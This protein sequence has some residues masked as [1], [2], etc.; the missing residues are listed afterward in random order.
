[1]LSSVRV[2]SSLP[3][4]AVNILRPALPRSPQLSLLSRFYSDYSLHKTAK[5]PRKFFVGGNFKMYVQWTYPGDH[6]RPRAQ[7]HITTRPS[8]ALA[9]HHRPSP[10][11]LTVL[12]FHQ[13]WGYRNPHLHRHQPQ[14]RQPRPQH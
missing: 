13:E 4:Q 2:F 9:L 8:A 1:M 11:Q 5:M 14:R 6:P 10:R 7:S 3:S 12:L